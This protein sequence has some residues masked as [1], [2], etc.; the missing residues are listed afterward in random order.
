MALSTASLSYIH[1]KLQQLL[2]LEQL[3]LRY[4][5]LLRTAGGVRLISRYNGWL[6]ATHPACRTDSG[7][8][9]EVREISR[10]AQNLLKADKL[11]AVQP[12][13]DGWRRWKHRHSTIFFGI[14]SHVPHSS[15]PTL[16]HSGKL[17]AELR[18]LFLS[19][20]LLSFN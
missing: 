9:S 1:E 10:P 5:S 19:N 4:S 17:T 7:A 3:L 15:E 12:L 13:R 20:S 18:G 6:G 11:S 2:D 16:R 8:R 14:T